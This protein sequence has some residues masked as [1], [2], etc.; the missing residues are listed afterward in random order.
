MGRLARVTLERRGGGRAQLQPSNVPAQLW[1]APSKKQTGA[2]QV[3]HLSSNA[4]LESRRR[5]NN[6]FGEKE[7][8][9]W[10]IA[11]E[12]RQDMRGLS[13]IDRKAV[14]RQNGQHGALD[15]SVL[16]AIQSGAIHTKDTLATARKREREREKHKKTETQQSTKERRL[17]PR[18]GR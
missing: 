11:E 17:Q 5:G 6:S 7:S 16:T 18:A 1:E 4:K 13:L 2:L 14:W 9:R 12:R 15:L 8:A 10:R 3:R